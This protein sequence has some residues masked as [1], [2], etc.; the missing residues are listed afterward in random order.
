MDSS[1]VACWQEM[2]EDKDVVVV[3]PAPVA[4]R[5]EPPVVARIVV[6]IR[7]DGSRTIARGALQDAL[8]G[9]DVKIQAE[10]TTPLSLAVSLVR[11]MLGAPALA[12]A[13]GGAVRALRGRKDRGPT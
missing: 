5:H 8:G 6:E 7:S 4:E 13:F 12:R 1:I 10:G 2:P 9:K 11:S 3:E